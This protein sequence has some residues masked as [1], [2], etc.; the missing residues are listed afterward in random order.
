MHAAIA[1]LPLLTPRCL[2]AMQAAKLD[3]GLP[4]D[5]SGMTMKLPVAPC[6][7]TVRV[8]ALL[9]PWLGLRAVCHRFTAASALRACAGCSTA[10]KAPMAVAVSSHGCLHPPLRAALSPAPIGVPDY[11]SIGSLSGLVGFNALG[12]GNLADMQALS[13][14]QVS[15][16]NF[17]M[18]GLSGLTSNGSPGKRMCG[19]RALVGG[20]AR[21]PIRSYPDCLPLC[22][23]GRWAALSHCLLVA[24]MCLLACCAVSPNASHHML[25]KQRLFVVVHKVRGRLHR[26]L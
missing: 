12:T 20:W 23:R 10:C 19:P 14:A 3:Y 18:A 22:C 5:M 7:C 21:Q 16:A 11:S 13:A 1:L 15:L 2:P 9:E 6:E 25:S 8:Y 4:P 26:L 17:G 24:T